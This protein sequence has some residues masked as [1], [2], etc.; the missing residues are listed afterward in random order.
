[1]FGISIDVGHA[2]AA[3]PLFQTGTLSAGD[4]DLMP[5]SAHYFSLRR[6][7]RAPIAAQHNTFVTR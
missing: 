7:G 1:M 3:T 5:S 2:A 4:N 6:L